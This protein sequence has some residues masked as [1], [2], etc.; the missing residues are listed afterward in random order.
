MEVEVGVGEQSPEAIWSSKVVPQRK[1]ATVFRKRSVGKNAPQISTTIY[2]V[3]T[4][5]E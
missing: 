5:N 2:Q 4:G 1:E 3:Y